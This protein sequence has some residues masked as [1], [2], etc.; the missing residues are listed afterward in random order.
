MNNAFYIIIIFLMNQIT[1]GKF[2]KMPL[3][4]CSFS[5]SQLYWVHEHGWINK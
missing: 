3:D 2:V 4:Q 1:F 5:I